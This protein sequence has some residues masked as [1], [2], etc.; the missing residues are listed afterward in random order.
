MLA[1]THESMVAITAEGVYDVVVQ[2][3]GRFKNRPLV[4]GLKAS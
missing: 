4:T 2:Q 3:I 1:V